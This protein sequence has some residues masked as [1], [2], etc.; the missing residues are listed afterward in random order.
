MPAALAPCC[1]TQL[2]LQRLAAARLARHLAPAAFT[3]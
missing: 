2:W 1:F 3:K